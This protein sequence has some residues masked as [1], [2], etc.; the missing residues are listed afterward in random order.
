MSNGKCV[1]CGEELSSYNPETHKCITCE[2]WEQRVKEISKNK[3][4]IA[5]KNLKIGD[6]VKVI[7]D[8]EE[9]VIETIDKK[10]TLFGAL[11]HYLIKFSTN[12]KIGNESWICNDFLFWYYPEEIELDD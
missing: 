2:N 12:S 4:L 1:S 9:G 7:A 3:N 11:E 6:K 10:N 8:G 5:M